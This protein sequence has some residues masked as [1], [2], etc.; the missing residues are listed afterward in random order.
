MSPIVSRASS[1]A[2][3]AASAPAGF[4]RS[5]SDDEGFRTQSALGDKCSEGALAGRKKWVPESP[6]APPFSSL[7]AEDRAERGARAGRDAP[8]AQVCLPQLAQVHVLSGP[9]S[10][11]RVHYS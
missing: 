11:P 8:E 1:L 4:S 6:P 3:K 2:A 5:L 10:R 9:V 7:Q